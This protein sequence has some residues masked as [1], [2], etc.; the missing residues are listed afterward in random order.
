MH[1]DIMLYSGH[2]LKSTNAVSFG[3]ERS[4]A[5]VMTSHPCWQMQTLDVRFVH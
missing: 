5:I 4:F 2:W 1:F 3:Q